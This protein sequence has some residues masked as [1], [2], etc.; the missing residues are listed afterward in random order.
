MPWGSQTDSTPHDTDYLAAI[1]DETEPP[2]EL[3]KR[4]IFQGLIV[5]AEYAPQACHFSRESLA[6]SFIA[7]LYS[8]LGYLFLRELLPLPS[9]VTIR[10]KYRQGVSQIQEN[11]ADRT[12]I[13]KVV[14]DYIAQYHL[15]PDFLVCIICIRAFTV[16]PNRPKSKG[17]A[18]NARPLQ[19]N[20]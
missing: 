12:K 19:I 17:F 15:F 2:I 7:D 14:T 18:S 11:L 1:W 20:K 6:F 16:D 10:T 3:V 9:A 8:S 13:Q 5:N 4:R